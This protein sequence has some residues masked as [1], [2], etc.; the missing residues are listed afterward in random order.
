MP[1]IVTAGAR[2][3]AVALLA[4]VV[5]SARAQP[6]PGARGCCCL[7]QAGA[8]VCAEK[9][10]AECLQ[11][12]PAAPT[13]PKVADW[14]KAWDAAVAASKAQEAKPMRGGWIAESCERAEARSGCCCFPK[15]HPTERERFDC[16]PGMSEF[17][18]TAECSMFK[19]G[20]LPSGC[21][22]TVGACQP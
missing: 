5:V 8:Y 22:W 7:V 1:T 19:D 16:K 18:C 21:K 17:D 14:K 3:A 20:R 6:A 15:L 9:T 13:Y 10:Q 11:L 12:Q 4:L 2:V